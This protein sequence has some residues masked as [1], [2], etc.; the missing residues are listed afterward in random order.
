MKVFRVR[1]AQ[2]G[3]SDKLTGFNCS[4]ENLVSCG[5]IFDVSANVNNMG[6]TTMK[7]ISVDLEVPEGFQAEKISTGEEGGPGIWRTEHVFL[8]SDRTGR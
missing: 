7:D 2:A 6:N 1:A 4:S 3:E 8:E 5:E